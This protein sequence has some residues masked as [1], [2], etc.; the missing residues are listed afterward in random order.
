[1]VQLNL[2]HPYLEVNI[3]C[4]KWAQMV[5]ISEIRSHFQVDIMFGCFF[6]AAWNAVC[7]QPHQDA[8][9]SHDDALDSKV[10]TVW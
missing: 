6:T 10:Q 5:D 1:V 8:V 7:F 2:G 4:V 9:L 3:S